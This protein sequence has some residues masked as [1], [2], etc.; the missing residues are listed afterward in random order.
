MFLVF[1]C[2]LDTTLNHIAEEGFNELS[3]SDWVVGMSVGN[4]LNC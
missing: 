1:N 4:Y 2:Q 3:G